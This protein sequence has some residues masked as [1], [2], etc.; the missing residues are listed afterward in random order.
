ME[1]FEID[2]ARFD[3]DAEKE[4]ALAEHIHAAQHFTFHQPQPHFDVAKEESRGDLERLPG[5][6]QRVETAMTLVHE[7]SWR[8][9]NLRVALFDQ[10]V[11]AVVVHAEFVG[12]GKQPVTQGGRTDIVGFVVGT[13][14]G[15]QAIQREALAKFSE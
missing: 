2:P 3:R 4:L 5:R 6:Y 15:Q 7:G 9:R 10:A 13:H 12:H 1:Q 14:H 8:T 11:A